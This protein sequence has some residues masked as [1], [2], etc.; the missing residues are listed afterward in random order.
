MDNGVVDPD[1]GT[2]RK[3]IDPKSGSTAEQFL[4]IK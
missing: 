1:V 2:M 4:W 3:N